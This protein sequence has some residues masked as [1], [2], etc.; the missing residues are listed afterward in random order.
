MH[1]NQNAFLDT[2]LPTNVRQMSVGHKISSSK[3]PPYLQIFHYYPH[4]SPHQ[5]CGRIAIEWFLSNPALHLPDNGRATLPAPSSLGPSQGPALANEVEEEVVSRNYFGG[6]A[7]CH[8]NTSQCFWYWR[9]CKSGF[10]LV[11][12]RTEPQA[13]PWSNS[14]DLFVF[15]LWEFEFTY[16]YSVT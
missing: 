14:N 4:P 5:R 8:M 13:G 15:Q 7:F 16:Y 6:I 12:P 3:N 2:M 9:L 1:L 10:E 11:L